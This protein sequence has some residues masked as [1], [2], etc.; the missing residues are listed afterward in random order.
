MIADADGRRREGQGRRRRQG[1]ET[2]GRRRGLRPAHRGRG[3]GRGHQC[4]G[5]LPGRRQPGPDRRQQAHRRAAQPGGRGG[6]GDLGIE[7]DHPERHRRASTRWSPASSSQGLSIYE[8][9]RNSV[10]ST[11]RRAPTSPLCLP[12]PPTART[13]RPRQD[14]A[15]RPDPAPLA[16]RCRPTCALHRLDRSRS[17]AP[18]PP[19]PTPV[20]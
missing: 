2:R 16:R 19:D 5:R 14:E 13:S 9:L 10:A 12:P 8:A 18:A 11:R 17:T 1:Q 3:R 4:A 6:Q 20:A 7:P 15:T